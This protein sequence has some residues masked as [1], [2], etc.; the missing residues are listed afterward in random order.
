MVDPTLIRG[1]IEAAI[2]DAEAHVID[3]TGCGDHFAAR[4]IAEAFAGRS[5]V[6]R[7]RMVY[8]PLQ[9][10]LATGELH[11]LQLETYTPAEWAG[12]SG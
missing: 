11:A 7:H 9:D 2:A 5:P 1:R 8:A 10:L 4:V 3:A 6:E 12:V